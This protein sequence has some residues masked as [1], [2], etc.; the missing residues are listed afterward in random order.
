MKAVV[1]TF[2]MEKAL[3]V[4]GKGLLREM[5][6]VNFNGPSFP[7]LVVWAALVRAVV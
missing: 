4:T 2:N 6:I 5:S 1:A 7:A 3:L